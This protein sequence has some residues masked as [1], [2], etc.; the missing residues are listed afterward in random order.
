MWFHQIGIQVG[1]ISRGALGPGPLL[2]K[3]VPPS[4][5]CFPCPWT[6]LMSHLSADLVQSV[7]E[8][9]SVRQNLSSETSACL[10]FVTSTP[11]LTPLPPAR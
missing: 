11:F 3:A 9:E 1:S 4:Q 6:C 7:H 8:I 5:G 10:S 2:S